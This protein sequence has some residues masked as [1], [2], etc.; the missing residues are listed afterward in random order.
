MAPAAGESRQIGH[1]TQ[2][3]ELVNMP[4]VQMAAFLKEQ[5]I[6]FQKQYRIGGPGTEWTSP[7]TEALQKSAEHESADLVGSIAAGACATCM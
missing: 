2:H 6:A 4:A 5:K 7:E 3:A 1:Y